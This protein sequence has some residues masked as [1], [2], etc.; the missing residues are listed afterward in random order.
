MRFDSKR[1]SIWLNTGDGLIEFSLSDKTF[2]HIDAFNELTKL[3]G[4]DRYVGIDI[5]RNGKIWLAARPMGI[6]IY[7]PEKAD[8][9]QILSPELQRK[10]GQDNLHV[11]CDHDGI[12]WISDYLDGGIVEVIAD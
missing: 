3:N 8:L 7:D 2:R 9:I 6:V 1:N 12:T 10:I 4:Y 11:Y 5:D